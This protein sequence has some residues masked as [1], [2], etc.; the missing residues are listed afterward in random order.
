VFNSLRCDCGEQL[1]KALKMI[2]KEGCGVLLYMT[3]EGR[4]IGLANKIKAYELQ[5]E[6]LDTVEA[7]EKLGFPPDLRDYGI[8]AQILVDIGVRKIRLITNNPKKI[9]GLEGF[10]LKIVDRVKIQAKVTSINKKYLL[11][12]KKKL[13]HLL[14]LKEN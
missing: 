10:N 13:G 11:T 12:K 2:Q 14:E 9:V 5:D 7:N 1:Q 8:G 6:G 4:G 3:D